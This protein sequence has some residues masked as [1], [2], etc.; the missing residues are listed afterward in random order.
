MYAHPNVLVDTRW[1]ADHLDDPTVRVVEVDM[2]PDPYQDAHIPGAVFWH[3][4]TEPL[5]RQMSCDRS[6]K[7]K[8]S[9][10]T[11]RSSPTA[12]LVPDQ[13]LSVLS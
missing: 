13:P 3:I 4:P 12:R 8:A 7:L 10:K 11:K 5:S 6:T 9:P 2:S 1:L